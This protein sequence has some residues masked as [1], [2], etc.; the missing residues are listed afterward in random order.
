MD[1]KQNDQSSALAGLALSYVTGSAETAPASLDFW[2]HTGVIDE[3]ARGTNLGATGWADNTSYNFALTYTASL[4]EVAVNGTTELSYRI[5]DNGG[6][7]FTP[8]AFGLYNYSQ[9]YVRYAGI[10]EEAATVRLPTSL[11]LL[12]GGLGGFAVARR[13]KAG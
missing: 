13:R 11:P 12:L 6:V 10:T 2:A 8:G 4:I 5:A 1:C 3:V 7:A 9:D